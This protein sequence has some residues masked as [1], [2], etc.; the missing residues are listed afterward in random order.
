MKWHWA[1]WR[2]KEPALD[3]SE[4]IRVVSE[5]AKQRHLTELL[6]RSPRDV[7][8]LQQLIGNEALVRMLGLGGNAN[9]K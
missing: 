8:G 4:S 7:L 3:N 1:F 5:A 9:A 2:H 6:C